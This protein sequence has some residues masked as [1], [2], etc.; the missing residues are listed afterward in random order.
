MEDIENKLKG[1]E[2][3]S[4]L[5]ESISGSSPISPS[6]E[7]D[8]QIRI[9]LIGARALTEFKAEQLS[10]QLQK[11]TKGGQNIQ[12]DLNN[13]VEKAAALSEEVARLKNILQQNTLRRDVQ[14]A[15]NIRIIGGP[16]NKGGRLRSVNFRE[17][18]QRKQTARDFPT[19]RR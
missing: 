3:C 13:A 14:F 10:H 11:L 1:I 17:I 5:N 19:S 9:T 8:G 4:S 16:K 2:T 15:E 7:L 18:F 6:G 12:S